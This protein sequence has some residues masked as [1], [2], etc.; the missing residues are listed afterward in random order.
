MKNTA[1]N[2]KEGIVGAKKKGVMQTTFSSGK[3]RFKPDVIAR[4]K[5]SLQMKLISQIGRKKDI[6]VI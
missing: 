4:T 6:L 1:A 5:Q 3:P 2:Q